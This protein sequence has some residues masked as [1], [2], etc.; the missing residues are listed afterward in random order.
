MTDQEK[1]KHLTVKLDRAYLQHDCLMQR[2]D[3]DMPSQAAAFDKSIKRIEKL[4]VELEE[5]TA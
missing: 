3:I 1:I 4:T 2:L 5:A